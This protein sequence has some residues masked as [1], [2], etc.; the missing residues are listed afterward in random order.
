MVNVDYLIGIS[1]N[2]TVAYDLH[3][4]CQNNKIHFI[5]LKQ[6]HHGSLL[7]QFILLCNGINIIWYAEHIGHMFHIRMIAYNQGYLYVPLACAVTCQQ[8][9]QAV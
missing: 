4:T 1:G 9:K 3:V 7:L 6:I 8:V 2:H 5:L